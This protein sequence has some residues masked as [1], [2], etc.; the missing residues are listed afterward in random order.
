MLQQLRDLVDVSLEVYRAARQLSNTAQPVNRLPPEVLSTIFSLIPGEHPS[1]FIFPRFNRDRLPDV[2]D[3]C[4]VLATC[5]YWRQVVIGRS[6]LWSIVVTNNRR[7][8]LPYFQWYQGGPLTVIVDRACDDSVIAL[9][10]THH[11][12]VRE[13]AIADGARQALISDIVMSF[14]FQ[15]LEHFTVGSM[16]VGVLPR[17][18]DSPRLRTLVLNHFLPSIS[19]PTLTHLAI[20]GWGDMHFSLGDLLKFVSDCPRLRTLCL[21]GMGG[22]NLRSSGD[23][24]KGE[25]VNLQSLERLVLHRDLN[26]DEFGGNPA[27]RA[28]C[29]HLAIPTPCIVE[30]DYIREPLDL[31]LFMDFAGLKEGTA[32]SWHV[33]LSHWRPTSVHYALRISNDGG[34]HLHVDVDSYIWP[35]IRPKRQLLANVRDLWL[36]P[37]SEW[38]IEP[39]TLP[40]LVNLETLVICL[41]KPDSYSAWIAHVV[42]A[43]G[44]SADQPQVH[45]PVLKTLRVDATSPADEVRLLDTARSRAAAGNPLSR[46]IVGSWS[47]QVADE[48]RTDDSYVLREYDGSGALVRIGDGFS[49]GLKE[50]FVSQQS[51]IC[52]DEKEHCPPHWY[53][54]RWDGPR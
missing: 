24:W 26:L 6:S 46:V 48:P 19:I 53:C 13:L 5:R 36:G 1:A 31:P 29:R 8:S 35:R 43:L 34:R 32:T 22:W 51:A 44:V 49:D 40:L 37:G 2:R 14:P 11:S 54:W 15:A 18:A 47:D 33:S 38:V 10:R 41:K 28:L 39:F 52:L 3:L 42:C 27:G 9:L 12:E 7:T 16:S 30:S 21:K 25:V 45:C 4:P 23:D 50:H 20:T 17:L